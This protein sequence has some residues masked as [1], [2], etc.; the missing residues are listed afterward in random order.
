MNWKQANLN[1]HRKDPVKLV[2]KGIR[3]LV[4][5]KS[6]FSIFQSWSQGQEA[7]NGKWREDR[8]KEVAL[9]LLKVLNYGRQK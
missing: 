9:G 5:E 3:V 8:E 7:G 2:E 6:S 1:W 4:A